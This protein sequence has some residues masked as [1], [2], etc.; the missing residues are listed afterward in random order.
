MNWLFITIQKT[1]GFEE[2]PLLPRDKGDKLAT[3]PHLEAAVWKNVQ[4]QQLVRIC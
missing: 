3:W 2:C 1:E 4:W